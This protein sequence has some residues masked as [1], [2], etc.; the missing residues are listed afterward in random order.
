MGY[1]VEFSDVQDAAERVAGTVKRTVVVSSE[2]LND[3]AGRE[4]LLSAKTCSTLAPSSF[5]VRPTR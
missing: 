2:E 1:A 4:V 5:A 3:I